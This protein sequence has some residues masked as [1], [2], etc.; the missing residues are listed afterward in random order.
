VEVIYAKRVIVETPYLVGR[1]V[2]CEQRRGMVSCFQAARAHRI[3]LGIP[4]DKMVH[5]YAPN[6]RVERVDIIDDTNE[7]TGR[8]G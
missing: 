5:C 3:I 7:K 8:I 2:L 6:S 4:P 1:I